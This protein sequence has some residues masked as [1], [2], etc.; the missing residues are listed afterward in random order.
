MKRIEDSFKLIEEGYLRSISAS[1]W[2][3]DIPQ[4]KLNLEGAL[5]LPDMK[6]LE[7]TEFEKGS[8][9]ISSSGVKIDEDLI[10]RIY[11]LTHGLDNRRIGSLK[12][13][14]SKEAVFERLK[15]KTLIILI[16][17]TIKTFLV[18]FLIL[19]IFYKLIM[20]HL[21]SLQL[22]V[23]N[24]KLDELDKPLE[25]ER[26]KTNKKPD[27]FDSL[28]S[29]INEMRERLATSVNEVVE[30]KNELKQSEEKFKTFVNQAADALYVCDMKGIITDVNSFATE[31]TGYTTKELI[32]KPVTELDADYTTIEKA[33]ELW[34]TLQI[35]QPI[36][37]ESIHRRKD[38][39][40]FPVEIRVALI[41]MEDNKAILGLAR[42]ITKRKQTEE[43]LKM[44][45][46][47][48]EKQVEERTE[49]LKFAMLQAE[50][51]NTAKSEFLAN[52]SHEL[53][54]PMHHILSYSKYGMEKI[55]LV[56]SQ[57][58]LHYFTQINS[59]GSRLMRLLNDL[60]DLSKMEAGKMEYHFEQIDIVEII[61]DTINVTIPALDEKN[62][63]IQLKK[64]TTKTK[65]RIDGFKISQVMNNLLSNAIKFSFEG[66][67]ITVKIKSSQ[68]KQ[69][70]YNM[71]A[72]SVIDNGVGIPDKERQL[73]FDKFTQSSKTKTGSG[74]TGLGLAICH[75]IIKAHQGEIWAESGRE[76]G[77]TIT[78]TVPLSGSYD[79]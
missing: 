29:A 16:S 67:Q 13:V 10:E 26:H 20:R 30:T 41:T 51:A 43:R 79:A 35:D 58:L 66:G 73:I 21:V 72:V 27:L 19:V 15:S 75:E 39:S 24:L 31:S 25:I 34:S 33:R 69:N 60:L 5:K 63:S 62:L 71:L 32:G 28:I 12:T 4:V 74:G 36:T 3:L 68:E 17:Q 2:N 47:D 42:D 57:K 44:A 65:S 38:G 59:S 40:T 22:Y 78:F 50:V 8:K 14:A 76:N 77:T 45:Y 1:L 52:I 64:E 6:Y 54:N 53:R 48:M 23:Q 9:L 18:S 61:N 70:K 46:E 11:P 37:I 49:E 55:D 56:K 7:V